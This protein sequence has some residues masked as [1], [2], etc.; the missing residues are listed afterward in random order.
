MAGGILLRTLIWQAVFF[1]AVSLAWNAILSFLANRPSFDSNT[2]ESAVESAGVSSAAQAAMTRDPA[3]DPTADRV[4]MGVHAGGVGGGR[5]VSR[6]RYSPSGRALPDHQP[7]M[8]ILDND[9]DAP[10]PKPPALS[11]QR[12]I[13]FL[14]GP[15]LM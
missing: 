4:S 10:P 2:I 8:G 15:G 7:P 3:A 6:P 13:G 11:D 9:P 14:L 1:S 5:W 12:I